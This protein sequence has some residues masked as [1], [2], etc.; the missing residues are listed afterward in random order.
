MAQIIETLGADL[1]AAWRWIRARPGTAAFVV[2]TVAATIGSTT[3]VDTLVD[4]VVLRPLPVRE[5]DRLV[6]M[7]NARVERDRAPFSYPDLADYRD[8]TTALESLASFTNWTANLT[9]R[10]E[11]ERLEGVRVAPEFFAVL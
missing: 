6:W 1:R 5:P 2:A 9:G 7:W 11:A 4:H 8:G 3:A 10:G